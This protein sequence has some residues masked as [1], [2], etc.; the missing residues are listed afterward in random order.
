M[1]RDSAPKASLKHFP[2]IPN[3]VDEAYLKAGNLLTAQERAEAI[4]WF[5]EHPE[6]L[7]G[8][9]YTLAPGRKVYTLRLVHPKSKVADFYVTYLGRENNA[10]TGGLASVRYLQSLT[11]NEWFV[12]KKQQLLKKDTWFYWF[13]SWLA[14]QSILENIV[15]SEI[16]N[17]SALDKSLGSG[18][19]VSN[20]GYYHKYLIG[21]QLAPGKE[22]FELVAN[23]THRPQRWLRIIERVIEAAN[24]F[25]LSG[26]IH[27]DLKLE[28]ILL[29]DQATLIDFQIMGKAPQH[30]AMNLGAVHGRAPELSQM[31]F[32][33]NYS[34]ATS[35]YSLGAMFRYALDPA[36]HADKDL[37]V[38]ANLRLEVDILLNLM[39]HED[40]KERP[41]FANCRKALHLIGLQQPNLLDRVIRVGLIDLHEYLHLSVT[42]KSKF[43]Q[44]LPELDEIYMIDLHASYADIYITLR[45]LFENYALKV[46]NQVIR[47]TQSPSLFAALQSAPIL[48]ADSK[49]PLRSFLFCTTRTP[50]GVISAVL[51]DENVLILNVHLMMKDNI[52]QDFLVKQ[53]L[54]ALQ[55][56]FALAKLKDLAQVSAASALSTLIEA[57]KIVKSAPK[58]SLLSDVLNPCCQ[59]LKPLFTALTAQDKY[60]GIASMARYA[61][62]QSRRI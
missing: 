22:L 30:R 33:A 6:Q 9:K 52:L 13:Q 45:K 4:A 43:L 37:L 5:H 36:N 20:N 3:K 16:E 8:K 60:Y 51:A 55:H 32:Y 59:V 17:L 19:Y 11:T 34:E 47:S 26:W 18:S 44:A 23:S 46:A 41:T 35:V 7:R 58:N 56:E 12:L 53:H 61:L 14:D 10:G 49:N 38:D 57:I 40:P 62:V 24:A 21:M 28:N 2:A 39:T 54:T 25:L 42:E 48:C 50:E 1:F 15:T 31:G 27:D 29:D